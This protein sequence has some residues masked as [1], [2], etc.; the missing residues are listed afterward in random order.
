MTAKAVVRD[1]AR[2]LGKPYALGDKLAKLIP[3]DLGI[4]LSKAKAQ[5]TAL[6]DFLAEDIEAAEVMSMSEKLEG[7]IRNVGTHAGGVIIA[8]SQLVNFAPIY[9]DANME[10]TVS[11]YDKKSLEEAGLVKF[12]F[13]GLR[14]LTI[15]D[16]AWKTIYKRYPDK[17]FT[18]QNELPL[19]DVATF[20]MLQTGFTTGVFQLES[21][22][23]QNLIRQMKPDCFEDIAA[24]VALFRP[25]PLQSGMVEDFNNRKHGKSEIQYLH[26][27]LEDILKETYGVILYQEQV[28]KIPQ[29]MCGYSLGQADVLRRA[30]GYKDAD[31]MAQQK[32]QFCKGAVNNNI[33]IKLAEH[34]FD[35]IEKFAGYGFNKSHSVAYAKVSYDTAWLK[36]HYPAEF[37]AAI[38][39]QDAQN[40]DKLTILVAECKRMQLQ[41]LPPSINTSTLEFS[42][43]D[44]GTI[45]YGLKAIKGVSQSDLELILCEREKSRFNSLLDFCQ[46]AG[47]RCKKNTYLPLLHS[48]ALDPL[49]TNRATIEHSWQQC[50]D[51]STKKQANKQ[52]GINDLFANML[53]DTL[54]PVSD[55]KDWSQRKKL[56]LEKQALGLYLTAHPT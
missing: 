13:L 28:M 18:N 41:I 42:V 1:T 43:H 27:L 6:V 32:E 22:G 2:A 50:L 53:E 56:Q 30:M 24:L 12:D 11:Q 23:M 21:S 47:V 54:A 44:S 17:H 46:R 35:L 26:P 19:D 7:L 34:I 40:T 55:I 15:I 5:E 45:I 48:G 49:S 38:L 39:T 52:A 20:E 31:I 14:T 8:P 29:V 33:D 37:M 4:T 3:F 51:I 10:N 25:G 9:V 36:T 16:K